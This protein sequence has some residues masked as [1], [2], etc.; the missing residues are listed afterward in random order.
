MTR[1]WINIDTGAA[2][3][4]PPALLCLDDLSVTYGD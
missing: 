4:L 3:G 2:S 1:T